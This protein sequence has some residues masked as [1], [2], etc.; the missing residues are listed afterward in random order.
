MSLAAG[1]PG[2]RVLAHRGG[3]SLAPENTLAAL[4]AGQALGARGVEFD[5]MLSGDG[6][7]LLMHDAD[8][9]RTVAGHG[10]V[11]EL[12]AGALLALDAGSWFGPAFAGER[13]PG[14]AQALAACAALGLWMNVE[15]KPA[16][17]GV[18]EATGAAVARAT[19]DWLGANETAA[20]PATTDATAGI[21]GSAAPPT[22]A[23]L[24]FSSFSRAALLAARQVAPGLPR[25]LLVETIP[26]DWPARVAEVGAVTLHA[27]HD[28]FTDDFLA[29]L[30]AGI[31]DAGLPAVGLLA[32]TVNDPVEARR[33]LDAGVAVCTDRPDLIRAG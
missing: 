14:Y 13:V 10:R 8:L 3:G 6:V 16:H 33:L 11:A 19:L 18:A 20:V 32:W 23:P 9:G 26:A 7:P 5:V 12:P 2:P 25:G 15:I 27:R 1:W 29:T 22:A 31:A 17:E 28:A 24:L 4:R 30:R 21:A